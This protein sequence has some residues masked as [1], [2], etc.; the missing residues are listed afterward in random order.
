MTF[1]TFAIEKCETFK[2]WM[3]P[4]ETK[5]L[6]S[7]FEST[8]SET[9]SQQST[10]QFC[11]RQV[12]YYWN[13]MKC[14]KFCEISL[15]IVKSCHFSL[16]SVKVLKG[17]LGPKLLVLTKFHLVSSHFGPKSFASWNYRSYLIH[18]TSFFCNV[19]M[20]RMRLCLFSV[21]REKG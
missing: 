18:N 2:F 7:F 15:T 13:F 19:R 8:K 21:C 5:I 3:C 17:F 11:E 20:S 6:Q 12:L 1:L 16:N 10:L 9:E 4:K 14:R